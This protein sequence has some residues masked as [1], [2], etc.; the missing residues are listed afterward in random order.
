MIN[1]ISDTVTKPTKEMLD[2]MF[3]A[4]VGDD[5]FAADPTVNALQEKCAAMFGMEASLFC[6]SGTMTN[7]IAI[8]VHTS[9]GDEVICSYQSHIYNFEGGGIARTSGAQVKLIGDDHGFITADQVKGAINPS[10]SHYS[11]TSLVSIENTTNKG[12][13]KCFNMNEV[14]AIAKVCRENGLKY[15]LDGARLFNAI[16]AGNEDSKEYGEAFDSISICL[17]KG[18]GAP[19]GSLLL[20]SKDFIAKS[21]RVRKVVGGGMRQAG[22]IA[23]AGIY[24]LDNNVN[25]LAE[26]HARAKYIAEQVQGA[27]F[28]AAT[29][30]PE[31]NILMVDLTIPAD[32]YL[33]K[34][35]ARGVLA[36]GFGPTR[37]RITTHL[38]VSEE[39]I[40][41]V[42]EIMKSIQ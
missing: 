20:G 22:Y 32:E 37:I 7:Q 26:D 31:T 2:A 28:I 14:K 4:E 9:P 33:D 19:V 41:K 35:E 1:L 34:L 8:N 21:H 38:D 13:G 17:S 18:L 6:P 29:V 12:G 11:N 40:Q 16:V 10:D 25:R 27:P 3:S 36:I 39:E 23:A 5:V 24:A 30:A 42:V 15:H